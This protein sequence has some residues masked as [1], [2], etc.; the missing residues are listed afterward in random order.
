MEMANLL[1]HL[2]MAKAKTSQHT[3]VSSIWVKKMAMEHGKIKIRNIKDNGK[4][5]LKMGQDNSF[6]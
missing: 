3:Q 5:M 2:L 4:I 6:I 1:Q